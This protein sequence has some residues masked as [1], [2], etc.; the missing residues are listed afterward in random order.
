MFKTTNCDCIFY[1]FIVNIKFLGMLG[2]I[3][4]W[5]VKIISLIKTQADKNHKLNK[6]RK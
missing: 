4:C 3:F 2:V 1:L 6:N 5:K